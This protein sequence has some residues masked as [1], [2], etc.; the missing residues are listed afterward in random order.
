MR[1]SSS[2]ADR[3]ATAHPTDKSAREG[4]RGVAART[5][6]RAVP[7][8]AGSRVSAWPLCPLVSSS[9]A[10][11]GVCTVRI[12]HCGGRMCRGLAEPARTA[13]RRGERRRRRGRVLLS[14]CYCIRSASGARTAEASPRRPPAGAVSRLVLCARPREGTSL[15]PWWRFSNLKSQSLSACAVTFFG[16]TIGKK[17]IL[18]FDDARLS[19]NR[20]H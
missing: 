6:A 5:H 3:C 13:P 18:L 4:A 7:P 12:V 17:I 20:R 15:W 2:G 16:K 8:A 11:A 14:T 19:I 9:R 10:S 1:R